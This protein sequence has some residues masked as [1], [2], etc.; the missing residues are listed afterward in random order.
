MSRMLTRAAAVLAAVVTAV[1]LGTAPAH[2]TVHEIV[3]Q[4]CSGHPHLE[5]PGLTGGSHA[6]NFAQP[7]NASGFISGV[8]PF[9]DGFLIQFNF[10]NP[11]AKVV[12]VGEPIPIG[13]LNGKP[14]YLQPIA[15]D[16][17]FPAF[18]NCPKLGTV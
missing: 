14:L 5:P 13:T 17:S 15:P 7:L 9:K 12:P 2:A 6:D 4:W 10:D 18:M 1:A 8:V 16:P 3:A 11:N